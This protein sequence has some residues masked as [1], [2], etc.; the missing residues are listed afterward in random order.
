MIRLILNLA[1]AALVAN[2]VWR[3]GSVYATHHKFVDSVEDSAEYSS[4][5]S[6]AEMRQRVLDLA[7]QY[8]VP[9]GPDDFVIR[10]EGGRTRIDAGYSQPVE[11]VPGYVYRWPFTVKLDV[12]D[13]PR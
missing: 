4:T 5:R 13:A 7:S 9:V 12:L 11:I 6:M 10:R 8:G 1:A 2:A 3:V